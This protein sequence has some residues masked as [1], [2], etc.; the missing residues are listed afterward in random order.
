L[1]SF[2]LIPALVGAMA[3]FFMKP[4]EV[5]ALL[6]LLLIWQGYSAIQ[7]TLDNAVHALQ[8]KASAGFFIGFYGAYLIF[9]LGTI[10]EVYAFVRPFAAVGDALGLATQI[11][12]AV[13]PILFAGLFVS[14]LGGIIAY[15]ITDQEVIRS[16]GSRDRESPHP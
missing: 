15:L 12:Q 2:V 4:P 16:E 14:V 8:P 7:S 10:W 1:I 11:W 5:L 9:L 6:A 13:F 3:A